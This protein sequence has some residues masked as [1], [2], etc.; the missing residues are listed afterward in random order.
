MA[1]SPLK[2]VTSYQNLIA[3]LRPSEKLFPYTIVGLQYHH[4][5]K[6]TFQSN[7]RFLVKIEMTL[8]SMPFVG[9]HSSRTKMH[10]DSL[11]NL[12][13]REALCR[14]IVTKLRRLDSV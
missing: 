2:M 9:L 12:N 6:L 5:V 4:E 8:K 11:L 14:H 1:N 3:I 13:P 7:L 10:S